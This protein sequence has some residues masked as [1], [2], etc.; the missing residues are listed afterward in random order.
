MNRRIFMQGIVSAVTVG[1][2]ATKVVSLPS[3][4]DSDPERFEGLVV[5]YLTSDEWE[6]RTQTYSDNP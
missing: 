1:I 6:R 4:S 5:R 2:P 3:K